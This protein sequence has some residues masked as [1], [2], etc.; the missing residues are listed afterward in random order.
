MSIMKY[1]GKEH[2]YAPDSNLGQALA[3]A[4]VDQCQDLINQFIWV[5]LAEKD[6]ERKEKQKKIWFE[7]N[8][9]ATLRAFETILKRDKTRYFVENKITYADVAFF[10]LFNVYLVLGKPEVPE[11]FA[12]YPLTRS[13]YERIMQEPRIAGH[14]K[15]RGAFYMRHF[16]L[17]I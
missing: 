11:E 15:T 8:L 13:L 2:G 4:I 16:S 5:Y 14:L 7:K 10:S 12:G 3:D 9:P 6:P 17:S 1:L